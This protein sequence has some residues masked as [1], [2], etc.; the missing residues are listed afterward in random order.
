M[1][2]YFGQLLIL[3]PSG[4]SPV[5]PPAGIS[6]GMLFLYGYRVLPGIYLGSVLSHIPHLFSHPS[7]DNLIDWLPSSI[8]ISLGVCLQAILSVYLI[9]R[10]VGR[11]DPLI[12]DLQIIKFLFLSSVIGSAVA[13]LFFSAE[14][15]YRVG[16]ISI[17]NLLSSWATW[18]VGDA[19]GILIVT[20][21]ILIFLAKPQKLWKKRRNY[22]FY[23]LLMLLLLSILILNYSKEQESA[24]VKE[25]FDRQSHLFDDALYS[26]L[27]AYMNINLILKSFFEN[28]AFINKDEFQ[29][30]S[31]AILQ[32]Y[33]TLR[34]I[35]WVPHINAAQRA[36][37]EALSQTE[38]HE[39]GHD[40]N[41]LMKKAGKRDQYFPVAYREPQTE[42]PLLGF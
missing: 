5:W 27:H 14:L 41:Q 3:S 39:L 20:P 23:P 31:S 33:Q 37:Y 32:Q 19:I 38:I 7:L 42:E 30:F 36:E 34:S 8:F 13:P 26:R 25:V 29:R 6:L 17:H 22:V 11:N 9:R 10:F 28:G 2:A 40:G 15:I 4:A 1:G 21:V 35:E 18:W 24:R 16:N 12:K